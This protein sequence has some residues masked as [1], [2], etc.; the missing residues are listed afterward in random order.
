[1]LYSDFVTSLM[2]NITKIFNL[3]LLSVGENRIDPR[4]L[5]DDR[6]KRILNVELR[7]A[8]NK[9]SLYFCEDESACSGNIVIKFYRSFYS[10]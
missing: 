5:I 6:C 3:I 2:N 1:V 10:N 4:T 7:C 8:G 9:R